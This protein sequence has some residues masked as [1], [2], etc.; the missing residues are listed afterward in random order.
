MGKTWHAAKVPADVPPDQANAWLRLRAAKQ[1]ASRWYSSNVIARVKRAQLYRLAA[2]GEQNPRV[3]G[4]LH[5]MAGVVAGQMRFPAA[6]I[7]AA[8]AARPVQARAPVT[9][10]KLVAA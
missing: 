10:A 5:H 7:V 2:K 1:S 3:P 8:D 6:V 4:G 9:G